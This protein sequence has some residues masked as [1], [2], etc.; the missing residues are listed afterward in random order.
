ML[1]RIE[2]VL[3]D[4]CHR[5]MLFLPP[6][7]AKSTYSSVLLPPHFLAR[8]PGQNILAISYS[9]DKAAEFG[10]KAR[11]I[12]ETFPLEL[13]YE[14][15][16]HSRAA[17]RWGTT[18]NGSY[19]CTGIGSGIAGY[20]A[21]LAL[22]D[23]PIGS[24]EDADSKL[25]R[26]K[27]WDWYNFDLKPR[28]KP[29]AAIILIMTR[30]H[31]DDL[32]GRLLAAEKGEW[33]V[34]RL[35]FFAEENDP[36]GRAPGEMLW[37]EWFKSDMF[38]KDGRVANALYQNN[39]TPEEGDFFKKEWLVGYDTPEKLP[40]NLRHYSS[41]DHAVSLKQEA[42]PTLLVNFGVDDQD[43]IWIKDDFFWGRADTGVIVDKMVDMA[44]QHKPLAW[45]AGKEHITSSIGPFL[46]RRMVEK[47]TYFLLVESVS[48]RDK[49]TRCQSIRGRMAQ[50]KVHFPTYHKRWHEVKH[51]ILSFPAGTHDEWADV[52]GE[53]GRGLDS[54][55][56]AE[57]IVQEPDA[58]KELAKPW[59][60]TRQWLLQN[61]K[62]VKGVLSYADR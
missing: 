51:E 59:K 10:R 61:Q 8:K 41:S 22:I 14:L 43:D 39:P 38:P 9:S 16:K 21:D 15:S 24:K 52:L 58:V 7:S 13:D 50:R 44:G 12:A 4:R 28:L 37:P 17:D 18:T 20:R 42:D 33:T 32:A 49:P 46:N 26:D 36:L 19:M 53:I 30:W 27:H 45:F 5:L 35:P 1:D 54:Q 31:E 11:N 3:H 23:D 60:P 47:G 57:T 56:K 2:D 62:D 34:V 29:N 40:T 48:R 25:I 6:G 55:V